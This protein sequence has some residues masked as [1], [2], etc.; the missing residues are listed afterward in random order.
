MRHLGRPASP[1]FTAAQAANFR[2]IFRKQRDFIG[3]SNKDVGQG[4]DDF[5]IAGEADGFTVLQNALSS[6]RKLTH[7]VARIIVAGLFLGESVRITDFFEIK[8]QQFAL[9]TLGGALY[10]Y[11]AWDPNP[12]IPAF[13]P[14]DA[15]DRLAARLAAG[16]P[17]LRKTLS[18]RLRA[19]APAMGRAWCE[20]IRLT[21]IAG[22]TPQIIEFI[23][24]I[25]GLVRAEFAVLNVEPP[26]PMFSLGPE[27]GILHR[28]RPDVTQDFLRELARAHHIDARSKP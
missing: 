15:I 6:A 11:R 4:I 23:Q 9:T 17:G 5:R 12:A 1:G 3:A 25:E 7:R 21:P 14:L 27:F 26:E 18:Q 28:E 20:R 22:S 10:A 2:R 19:E 16:R 24:R 13:I 8:R